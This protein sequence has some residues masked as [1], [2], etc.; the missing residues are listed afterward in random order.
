MSCERANSR[1]APAPAP[2]LAAAVVVYVLDVLARMIC[3]PVKHRANIEKKAMSVA[4]LNATGFQ[5]CG[6]CSCLDLNS[7]KAL[8]IEPF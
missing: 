6:L 5:T 8:S 4:I 1:A 2:A 3:P 7:E